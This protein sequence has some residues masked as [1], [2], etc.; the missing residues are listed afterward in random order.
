MAELYELL[1]EGKILRTVKGDCV[2]FLI[3][4][5]DVM[6]S[7]QGIHTLKHE[8][9]P[10]LIECY[11]GT[12]NGENYFR[13]YVTGLESFS[14]VVNKTSTNAE[15]FMKYL[16]SLKS[17]LE[18]ENFDVDNGFLNKNNTAIDFNDVY[19]D[20]QSGKVYLMYVPLATLNND[21][22]SCERMLS[23]AIQRAVKFNINLSDKTTAALCEKLSDGIPVLE[24]ISEVS[25]KYNLISAEVESQ[26][27]NKSNEKNHT[28][29]FA[30]TAEAFSFAP[31]EK[32]RSIFKR[33]NS[34]ELSSNN[35]DNTEILEDIHYYMVSEK[36]KLEFELPVGV[37]SIG[38]NNGTD[39][40][41]STLQNKA[42]SRYH[43]EIIV[44]EYGS[45]VI[46]DVG[47]KQKGS[48]NGT[49]IIQRGIMG[50]EKSTRLTPNKE[51]KIGQGS[52]IRIANVDFVI[53]KK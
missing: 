34:S 52:K 43:A 11:M 53:V 42:I 33:K 31:K 45:M 28:N 8:R 41:L 10:G 14:S 22:N 49:F 32:E 47:T 20:T 48:K 17:V 2:E 5:K 26:S 12:R 50:I 1:A 46:K 4:D 29:G 7:E 23:E 25:S 40:D 44:D 19:V 3:K 6:L 35:I 18:I 38:Q 15:S 36:L 16:V 13:Y 9:H 27:D 39:I 51:Y 30:Q 37:T 24:A 21:S